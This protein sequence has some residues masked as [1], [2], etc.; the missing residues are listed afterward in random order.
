MVYE[1]HG[2]LTAVWCASMRQRDARYE[3]YSRHRIGSL[4]Y[5]I[6]TRNIHNTFNF[7]P[8]LYIASSVYLY[9]YLY[10]YLYFTLHPLYL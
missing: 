9:L 2:V 7:V 1:V 6:L 10:V 3:I 8:V 5:L 4:A